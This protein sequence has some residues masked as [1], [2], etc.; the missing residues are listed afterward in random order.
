MSRTRRPE[1]ALR[2]LLGIAWQAPLVAVPFAGFF[3]LL[4]GRRPSEF[5]GYWLASLVFSSIISVLNWAT[6]HFVAARLRQDDGDRSTMVRIGLAHAAA[7][8]LG[9][10]LAAIVLD[11]TLAPGMLGGPR[12][13]ATFS[14]F[15]L[16]FTVLFLG[17]AT[18]WHLWQRALERAKSEQELQLA[19]RIQSS[20]L[21]SEFPARARIQLHATNLPSREVSG[22]FYDVVDAGPG[23]LL[24]AVADVSGKGVPAALL[25]SMLQAALRTQAGRVPSVAA[26][27]TTINALVCQRPA[28]G[29]FATFFLARVDEEALTITFTNAGHNFPIVFRADGSRLLLEDGGLVVGM[30]EGLP[31]AER[32]LA[33]RSGD[34][35]LMYT[36]GV[37]EA[38]NAAGEMFGEE[39]LMALVESLPRE[40]SA[41][42]L[43]RDVLA[44]VRRFLGELE[45]GD[46][47][48]VLALRVPD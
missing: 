48:T 39:R 47:V 25:S 19:R 44:G 8:L 7:S 36:D 4:Q 35:V 20:F 5:V 32:T 13:F 2:G 46:D 45:A 22:D 3:M 15:S 41:E 26:M 17:L 10:W 43:V 1:S 21:P 38:M 11:R 34:R 6:H 24:V 18:A 31:Y 12:A 30:M 16:L 14:M 37:T 29:Q 9:S 33:L 27:M 23:A 28:T 40:Q 42:A